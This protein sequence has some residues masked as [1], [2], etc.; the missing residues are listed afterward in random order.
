MFRHSAT[1]PR[2]C[3]H[4]AEALD[5]KATS[6]PSVSHV[7]LPSSD[8]ADELSG[9]VRRP[10]KKKV[11]VELAVGANIAKSASMLQTLRTPV[12]PAPDPWRT[13]LRLDFPRK[14]SVH[15][16]MG[17]LLDPVP[18]RIAILGYPTP[19]AALRAARACPTLA[20]LSLVSPVAGYAVRATRL[21]ERVC[22]NIPV[23][24]LQGSEWGSVLRSNTFDIVLCRHAFDMTDDPTFEMP[25]L[26]RL[27]REMF[28]IGTRAALLLLHVSVQTGGPYDGEVASRISAGIAK[29]LQRY[30]VRTAD[31]GDVLIDSQSRSTDVMNWAR[32]NA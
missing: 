19:R 8:R 13:V 27:M 9:A 7:V 5:G 31:I 6:S 14:A 18:K 4:D 3:D 1:A 20:S 28:R 26:D 30:D 22:P 23:L 11:I 32:R 21:A 2:R 15:E 24:S 29:H 10:Q 12:A 25:N 17:T 16:L